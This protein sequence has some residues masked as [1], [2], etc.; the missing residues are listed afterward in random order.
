MSYLIAIAAGY[1]TLVGLVFRGISVK[2]K[3][4]GWLE[5]IFPTEQ[6]HLLLGLF[7]RREY[8]E[9]LATCLLGKRRRQ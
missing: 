3:V 1:E 5:T 8:D 6:T 7:W 4:F 9:I 2:Q